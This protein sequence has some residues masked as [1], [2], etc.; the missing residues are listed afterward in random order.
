MFFVL[1]S[2]A[3]SLRHADFGAA[4][5][6]AAATLF[7]QNNVVWVALVN[8]S[9]AQDLGDCRHAGDGAAGMQVMG[10]WVCR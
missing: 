6:G 5:L 10:L 3:A 2:Y 8:T 7:R 9:M 4:L 1:A